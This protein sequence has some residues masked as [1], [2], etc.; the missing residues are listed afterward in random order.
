MENATKFYKVK[1]LGIQLGIF[2]TNSADLVAQSW[3]NDFLS[4]H[5][6]THFEL[7]EV[8]LKQVFCNGTPINT[9][10]TIDEE[11]SCNQCSSACEYYDFNGASLYG[12][13]QQQYLGPEQLMKPCD[14]F[15]LFLPIADTKTSVTM[16]RSD[17]KED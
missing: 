17:Y 14:L 1:Y 6:N 7:I 9:L 15:K 10:M 4:L 5:Q 13:L 8:P 2:A 16:F 3:L 12:Q 11:D